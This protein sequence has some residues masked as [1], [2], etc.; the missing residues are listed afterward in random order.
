MSAGDCLD[1]RGHEAGHV[2]P[3][4]TH[5]ALNKRLPKDWAL[6]S[7]FH[8]AFR[9]EP[10]MRVVLPIPLPGRRAPLAVDWLAAAGKPNLPQSPPNIPNQSTGANSPAQPPLASQPKRKPGDCFVSPR[11]EPP[12][13]SAQIRRLRGEPTESPKTTLNG[14]NQPLNR[15]TDSGLWCKQEKCETNPRASS[16]YPARRKMRNEPKESS[17]MLGRLSGVLPPP[18]PPGCILPSIGAKVE[19]RMIRSPGLPTP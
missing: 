8:E 3:K 17:R 4:K 15:T 19:F 16:R 10:S 12:T 7:G 14:R 11:K 9:G 6:L 13:S 5:N 2:R 18:I 1:W